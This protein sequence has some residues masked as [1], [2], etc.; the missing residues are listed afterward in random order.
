MKKTIL[1]LFIVLVGYVALATQNTKL[2]GAMPGDEDKEN[3]GQ[4]D[5]TK[6]PDPAA[7]LSLKSIVKAGSP[8]YNANKERVFTDSSLKED[9]YQS[10]VLID[11]VFVKV[12]GKKFTAIVYV[13]NNPTWTSNLTL[14]DMLSERDAWLEVNDGTQTYFVRLR[15]VLRVSPEKLNPKTCIEPFEAM[16]TFSAPNTSL[17]K[18]S[19]NG[20]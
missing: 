5:T 13:E 12:S 1:S 3:A 4:A 16:L 11:S 17:F 20:K 9:R 2:L 8:V 6:K 14:V 19:T 18:C 10:T 15:D 7:I